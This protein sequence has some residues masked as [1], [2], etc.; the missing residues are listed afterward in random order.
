M[1]SGPS[2][3]LTPNADSEL[4]PGEK[5]VLSASLEEYEYDVLVSEVME[6]MKYP[7]GPYKEPVLK[8]VEVE[9]HGAD[10]FTVKVILD[11]NKLDSF[12]YGKGDGTDRVDLWVRVTA[13]R[14]KRT[15]ESHIIVGEPGAWINEVDP[16]QKVVAISKTLFNTDPLRLEFHIL[17]TETGTRYAGD[18]AKA[19]IAGCLNTAL[20]NLASRKVKIFG[21]QPSLTNPDLKSC[22]SEPIDEHSDYDT[23]FTYLVEAIKA[24]P[25]PG[26]VETN[27]VSDSEFHVVRTMPEGNQF[28]TKCNYSQKS[29]EIKHSTFSEKGNMLSS[30]V[31]VLHKE[32]LRLEAWN[33]DAQ[34]QRN[35]GRGT[36][37]AFQLL[38]DVTLAKSSSWF[39][40]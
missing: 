15:L 21:D 38:I 18:R 31:L 19:A 24:P 23:F 34:G 37:K 1:G 20:G 12:G 7:I 17:A 4:E 25:G 8:A 11:G 33:L 28:T 9:E 27:E 2:V 13:N 6:C 22:V 10:D 16:A 26:S 5:C 29:G 32:P 3:E 14:E 30:T 35:A 36:A 39:G 40:W